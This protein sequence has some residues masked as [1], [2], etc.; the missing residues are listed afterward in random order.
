VNPRE[1]T[2]G[3]FSECTVEIFY[4]TGM[5]FRARLFLAGGVC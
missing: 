1:C 3:R 2:N 4:E 5:V